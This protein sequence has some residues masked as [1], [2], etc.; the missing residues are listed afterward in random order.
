MYCS[1]V[2]CK[3]LA[4]ISNSVQRTEAG[5]MGRPQFGLPRLLGMTL[6]S[7]QII[8]RQPHV[9]RSG[10]WKSFGLRKKSRS[11]SEAWIVLVWVRAR[12]FAGAARLPSW[13]HRSVR[14]ASHLA[15]VD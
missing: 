3:C 14:D 7:P 4:C 8:L 13:E 5:S 10:Q 2:R 9:G 1:C 15:R 11:A 12:V 6:D